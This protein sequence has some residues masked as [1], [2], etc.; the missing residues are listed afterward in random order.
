MIWRIEKLCSAWKII[1]SSNIGCK[2]MFYFPV[3]ITQYISSHVSTNCTIFTPRANINMFWNDI[4]CI[5]CVST[6][7]LGLWCLTTLS[8]IFQLYRGGQFYWWRKPEYPEKTTDLPRVTEKLLYIMLYRVHFAIIGIRTL[9]FSGDR[10]RLH[11]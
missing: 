10:H 7:G 5:F 9:N 4:T 8:T 1:F 2:T 6:C 11:S 3:N